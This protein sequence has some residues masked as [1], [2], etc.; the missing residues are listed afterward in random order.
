MKFLKAV[1]QSAVGK[2]HE[3]ADE[4]FERTCI[5]FPEYASRLGLKKF[6]P[7]LGANTAAV[8]REHVTLTLKTLKAVEALPEAAFHGDEW[9]DRRAFL[10]R[11][12]T[13]LL[14]NRDLPRWRT[15]PQ[16]HC[17]AAID[18]IFDL[19]VRS[20]ANPARALPAI[21]ARLAKI[22]DYLA[23]GAD[24]IQAPVPLWVTLA[25]RACAGSIEFLDALKTEFAGISPHPNR[26]SRL[27]ASA[28]RAF[29]EY[30]AAI[31]RRRPG[32]AGGFSIGRG[33][34]EFL[35]RE[36]LGL[37]VT[38]P[39]AR[40]TGEHL[41]ARHDYLLQSAA[42]RIGK[43]S[44]R[45]L[46]EEAASQWQP[47]G[48]LLAAYRDAT[49]RLRKNLLAGD[50]VTIPKG[51]KL[52]VLPVPPFLRHQFPTAAYSAPPPFSENQTGIFWVNDLSLAQTEPD[53][54]ISEIRQ[55]F[56]LELTSVHEGYPGH[57]LQ[58]VVQ[59]R[60]PSRLRRLFEHSIFY[61]G[62]TMWCEK[63][64]VEKNLVD[65]PHAALIQTHDALWRAHRIVIDCGLHDGSLTPAAAARR[66]ETGVHFTPARAA[67]D[68]N[69]YT[70]S[71]TVPMSY[72]LGRIEL[73]KLHRRLVHGE[74]WT[75][76]RF[77]DWVLSH[78]ALP[79]SWIWQA[80]LNT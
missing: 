24:C 11:L 25:E 44:A 48:S 18:S 76:R 47:R 39:E 9:L 54:K 26:T 33:H 16:I 7:L 41:V 65:F 32:A 20:T 6:E 23:A 36:R 38:L 4:W 10:A 42:A 3:T 60:H 62:W 52:S 53:R 40:A 15:N 80:R 56:G 8:H 14:F 78:G 27:L 21:E 68:V 67:G 51:E 17:D 37:D 71:P 64:A 74:G 29:A 19:V 34:F 43:K 75:L 30:A 49:A 63:L 69:W 77:N 55:H 61:E 31:R 35:I 1:D 73:E 66:L 59:F 50:L 79:W 45:T 46:I 13:D 5:L 58:F 57:H 2:L 22:P 72:L 28:S 12:R 70:S